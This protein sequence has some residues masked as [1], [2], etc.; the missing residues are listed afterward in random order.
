MMSYIF[1]LLCYV[2]VYWYLWMVSR[3]D[4][5]RAWLGIGK[6]AVQMQDFFW[7]FSVQAIHR[8]FVL[9]CVDSYGRYMSLRAYSFCKGL[10]YY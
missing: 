2:G 4:I 10:N 8:L 9:E 5:G 1:I 7:E 3:L 6:N